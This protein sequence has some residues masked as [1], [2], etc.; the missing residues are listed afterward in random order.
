MTKQSTDGSNSL[1]LAFALIFLSLAASIL[2]FGV[3]N[4]I[5]GLIGLCLR[6]F[7]WVRLVSFDGEEQQVV[8][9]G[10]RGVQ[11]QQYQGVANGHH[12]TSYEHSGNA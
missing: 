7:V 8:P 12:H 1:V 3:G 2:A 10:F 11:S 4:T 5:L 9:G 6:W